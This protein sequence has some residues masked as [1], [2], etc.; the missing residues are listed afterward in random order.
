MYFGGMSYI[1]TA[2]HAIFQIGQRYPTIPWNQFLSSE[3]KSN[4]Y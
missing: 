3:I 1:K 2:P 4:T